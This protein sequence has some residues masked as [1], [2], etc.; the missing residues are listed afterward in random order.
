MIQH[1]TLFLSDLHL[2]ST[3]AKADRLL[4]FLHKNDAETYYLVGDIVDLVRLRRRCFWPDAHAAVVRQL[5]ARARAGRRIVLIGG[6]HDPDFR[7]RHG[8]RPW[9]GNVELGAE[10]VHQLATGERLLVV[11]G[12]RHERDRR[13][14]RTT[15]RLGVTLHRVGVGMSDTLSSLRRTLGLGYWSLSAWVKDRVLFSVP[16]ARAFRANLVADARARGL[17]GV[18]AGHIHHACIQTC[19]GLIYANAGDWV[20]SCTALCESADG[21]LRLIRAT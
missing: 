14:V 9:H 10:A 1:R 17:D 18:V 15:I 7:M 4:T 21:R 5:R 6:N 2:G 3:S 20:E 12:D 13:E 19:D 16:V 8:A 11:H